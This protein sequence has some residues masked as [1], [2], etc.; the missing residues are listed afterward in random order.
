MKK[1]KHPVINIIFLVGMFFWT[2]SQGWAAEVIVEPYGYED[3]RLVLI[4]E[5]DTFIICDCPE[6]P[7]LKRFVQVPALAL[8]M[9]AKKP[10]PT[11]AK[12]QFFFEPRV[13]TVH[14][15]FDSTVVTEY[16]QEKLRKIIKKIKSLPGEKQIVLV[17]HTC[18]IGDPVYNDRLSRDRALAVRRVLKDQ[19]ITIDTAEGKGA[20]C[21]ISKETRLN[22]RVEIFVNPINPK[23]D[24]S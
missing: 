11:I 12:T 21:P 1:L 7:S 23:G 18:T 3:S 8:K 5:G 2:P 6:P 16:S 10:V 14:F 20:C 24:Q 9:T 4:E 17:G 19:D 22:R 15:G 13:F